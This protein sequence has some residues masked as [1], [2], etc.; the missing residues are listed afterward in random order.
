M[1]NELTEFSLPVD[2]YAAFDALS[3]KDLIVNRLTEQNVFTDQIFEGSN[4]SSIIDIIAYSYH[5]LLFYLNRTSSES[6]FSESEVYENINRIVKLLN[7][8]P[9]GFQTANLNFK[10]TGSAELSIGTYTIPRYTFV[11]AGGIAYSLNRDV[12]FSKNN[13]GIEVITSIGNENLLYQGKYEQYPIYTSAGEEFEEIIV[14]AGDKNI[15][16]FNM[17]VYVKNVETGR[18]SQYKEATSLFLHGP[19]DTVFEKRFN[20]NEKIE[21]KFGNNT[22]GRQ[23]REGDQ[24]AIYYLTSDGDAGALG[25]NAI[26]EFPFT[27]YTPTQF[28]TIREDVRPSNLTYMTF[29]DLQKIS[30][31]NDS[32]SA[33]ANP[34][35]SVSEIKKKAPIYFAGQ[36]KLVT[37]N[38]FD[39]FVERHFSN[40]I[41][42]V[43]TVNNETYLNGHLKYLHDDLQLTKPNVE[44]RVLYNQ[45][46]FASSTN[47][48][49]IYIYAVPK[50]NVKSSTNVAVNFLTTSQKNTIITDI[51]TNKMMSMN[52]VI[53]DPVYVAVDFAVANSAEKITTALKDTT[54]LY[55]TQSAQTTTNKDSIKD[56]ASAIIKKYFNIANNSLGQLVD[57]SGITTELLSID[58]VEGIYTQRTDNPAIKVDGLSVLV[59]NPV[60]STKDV[61]ITGQNLQLPYFKYPYLFNESELLSRIEVVTG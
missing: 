20:E 37:A 35:E 50:I 46:N 9:I 43:K 42:S 39:V 44:S 29:T 30:I 3:L 31:S 13:T 21:I 11:N 26:D 8:K 40:I 24:V 23:L 55:I 19:S 22:T 49:N 14:S 12:S 6:L 25:P 7:Y 47:F 48:N 5:V 57:L 18:W 33:Y 2:A 27:L 36:N 61:Q 4:M 28:L 60:Y 59:W 34:K 16:Y 17:D 32:E 54:K 51:E 1:S 38:D 53:I 52:P 10:A 41:S 45:I 15:D 58:G 56:Q